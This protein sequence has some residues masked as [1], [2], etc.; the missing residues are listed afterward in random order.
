MKKLIKEFKEFAVR[1]NVMDMAIGV[2][3][4]SAFSKIVSSLVHDIITPLL[5]LILGRIN[6]SELVVTIPSVVGNAA[7]IKIAYGNFLQTV[8]D[9]IIIALS[10]FL[11]VKA[12]NK[13]KKKKEET[14][15]EPPKPSSEERLLTEIRDLLKS[16]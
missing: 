11:A 9:F 12:I 4:G 13:I 7:P 6:I 16:K 10:I 8:L 1:G 2:I 15:A 3:I 14:P 5:S